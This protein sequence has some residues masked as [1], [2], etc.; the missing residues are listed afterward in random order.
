MVPSFIIPFRLVELSG[1]H[2]LRTLW[3]TMWMS[4]AMAAV[5]EAWLQ[6]L[7]RLGILN[8][9]VELIS[10]VILGIV[11]YLVL[12]LTCRPPVLSELAVILNGSSR[13]VLQKIAHYLPSS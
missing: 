7:R 12:V 10:T 4:L 5:T 3:P 1:K 9:P 11:F 8:A 13:P 2:F 6:G